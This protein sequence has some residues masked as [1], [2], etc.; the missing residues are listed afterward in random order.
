MK[1]ITTNEQFN[2][3][4]QS[5]KEII[6]KFYADWCPDCTRMNMFIGDILE[7]YNQNDWYELNKDEL[8]DLAE[9]YQVM[10]IPSLLIFKNGEKTAHLHSANAKTPEEVTEFLSEHIS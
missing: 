4:I 5:D 2:E 6:V 8:P 10:G 7:E 9:K 1:K 3:L